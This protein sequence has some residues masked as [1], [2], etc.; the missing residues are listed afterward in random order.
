M[1]IRT[2]R[3][4]KAVKF[5]EQLKERKPDLYA[6]AIQMNAR[7]NFVMWKDGEKL[8]TSEEEHESGSEA[9]N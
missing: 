6:R 3:P 8:S 9:E 4:P 5:L 1:S 2:D 7:D